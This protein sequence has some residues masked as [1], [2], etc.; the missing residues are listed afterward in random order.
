MGLPLDNLAEA[1]EKIGIHLGEI[2]ALS[3]IYKT[4]P[5]GYEDQ[6][7]FFNQCVIINTVFA[8]NDL[9]IEIKRIEKDLGR[10]ESMRWGPRLIDIDIL[11]FDSYVL[12]TDQLIIPHPSISQ[13]RFVLEPLAEICPHYIHPALK[14]SIKNLLKSCSDSNEIKRIL[15]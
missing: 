2:T 13:R 10:I 7:Y 11:L 15:Q 4:E 1:R 5:W 3:S 8:P 12:S 9:L 14:Q 6:N